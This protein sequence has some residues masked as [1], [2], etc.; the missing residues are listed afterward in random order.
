[1][2]DG[3]IIVKVK[4][5]LFKRKQGFAFSMWSWMQM[6]EYTGLAINDF[7]QLHPEVF[8]QK[9][10]YCA[11]LA[12]NYLNGIKVRFTEEDVIKWVNAL[13]H[14]EVVMIAD[15]MLKSRIG[16]QKISDLIDSD[17]EKKKY[18]PVTSGTTE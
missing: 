12:Y 1:M 9:A 3:T 15:T 7:D 8:G 11:A 14:S 4:K 6:S 13:P 5:G 10:N 2:S 18:G 17:D 16:G